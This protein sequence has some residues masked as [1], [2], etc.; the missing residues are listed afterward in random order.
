M[1]AGVEVF[2]G[3]SCTVSLP[4]ANVCDSF[5]LCDQQRICGNTY[6]LAFPFNGESVC[7]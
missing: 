4:M 1:Q 7:T 2:G 5:K 3:G 6:T